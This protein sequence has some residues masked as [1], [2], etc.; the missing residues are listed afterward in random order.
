MV[1][2]ILATLT[3]LCLL[4]ALIP[5]SYADGLTVEPDRTRLYEGEVLTVTVKG[6]MKLDIN[7][8]NLFNFDLSE[9]PAP[10]IDK[11]KPDFE[12][13]GQNQRYS[14][15]TVNNDMVGEITW[16]YQLAPTKT[17]KLTIP[18]LTFKDST[19]KPVTIEVVSGSPPDQ[20]NSAAR[21]SFIE[22][23]ADKDQVYVQEQ[24]ILTIKL[25]F[26]GNLIRGEL[27]EPEDPDTIIEPL[28]K[29]SEYTRYRDG[30]RYRVVERRY[31]L[32]PQKPGE[33]KLPPIRFEGQARTP[34]GQLKFLRD[35]QEFFAVTVK[36][37]P[38][39][40]TG[41]TWLPA[42]DLSLEESGLPTTGKVDTGE[43]LT[44]TLTLKASGLP[45]ETLP[46]LPDKAPDG[47]RAYPEQPQRS[48]DTTPDGLNSALSQTTA[49]VPVQAGKKTLPEI[50][51]PWWDTDTDTQKVAVIPATTLDVADAGSVTGL[52]SSTS[53][54][55][56]GASS[57][58]DGQSPS[59]TPDPDALKGNPTAEAPSYWP[60][61]SLGL[62][63]AWLAT[64]LGWLWSRRRGAGNAGGD[65]IEEDPDEQWLFDQLIEAVRHGSASVP[66]LLTRWMQRRFPDGDFQTTEDVVRFTGDATLRIE[67]E[68]LQ[69][70]LFAP[71]GERENAEPDLRALSKALEQLRKQKA[72]REKGDTLRPLYPGNLSS[73]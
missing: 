25:F 24:L 58:P 63:V 69:A 8:S 52:Q 28:G 67:L 42:S 34:E 31:A 15:R 46:P 64:L 71:D 66:G 35:S 6:T 5:A 18:A 3:G 62:A 57:S 32:Y 19:S 53:A 1:K 44:R 51:I 14:I 13:L 50:R 2:R 72:S 48:T 40:F 43:N 17:G 73:G 45:A 12:I 27:S 37:I 49:L 20:Q 9:L 22:L 65:T 41:D 33:L 23:S 70:R 36:D 10:D 59:D 16:T 38:A 47:I 29:Q 39:D 54:P 7:L 4:L 11:V 68:R 21:D 55:P 30:I 61:I 60:W 56:G 26:T